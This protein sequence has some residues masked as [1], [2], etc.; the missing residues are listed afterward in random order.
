MERKIK[1]IIEYDGTDFAGWQSQKNART[2]QDV[3]TDAM[4]KLFQQ[5][6]RCVGAGRTDSGVHAE[7]QVVHFVATKNLSPERIVK[8][9]N[10]YLPEDVSVLSAEEVPMEF[11]ARRNA[12]Q[13]WYRYRILN[14]QTPPAIERRFV[15]YIPYKLNLELIKKA[16]KILEGKHNFSA[17]RNIGC[18]ATRTI[19]HLEPIDL[20]IDGD[21]IALDFKCR[22][23]LYNMVRI[24]VGLLIEIGR[25]K[26][27]LSIIEEMFETGVRS[28]H[29]PTA[30]PQGLTLMSVLYSSDA[31]N[32]KIK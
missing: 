32:K 9:L 30:P 28:A 20:T 6:L 17:F 10:S 14:R 11:H 27:P 24:I 7:G 31:S 26:L 16:T 19:L 22:S 3:L 1:L 18:T 15:A 25:K 13:R 29:I 4:K 5:N 23:F 12:I 21:Y 8:G 2:V